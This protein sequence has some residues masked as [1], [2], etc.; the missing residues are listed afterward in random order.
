[1]DTHV[2]EGPLYVQHHK[3]VKKWRRGWAVLFANGPSGVA[4]LEVFEGE[5]PSGEGGGGW[6]ADRKVIRLS[7]C[8]TVLATP[9]EP[10]PQEDSASFCVRTVDRAHVFAAHAQDSGQWVDRIC[11]I[12][13]QGGKGTDSQQS[14]M[15][16][17]LIYESREQN[18]EFRVTMQRTEASERCGLQGAYWLSVGSHALVLSEGDT[19]RALLTWPYRLLRRYGH[20]KGSFSMEAGRRCESGPGS[21]T[22]DT[23]QSGQLFACVEAAIRE[24][25]ALVEEGPA[26]ERGGRSP[27]P[28]GAASFLAPPEPVYSQ[29][30]DCVRTPAPPPEPVYS[31]PLDSL[32]VTPPLSP[33][34]GCHHDDALD[35]LY[36][37]V[38]E[39]PPGPEAGGRE[40]AVCCKPE[41]QGALR[42][43]PVSQR[44]RDVEGHTVTYD[45]CDPCDPAE[46][47][48]QV[49]KHAP[50]HTTWDPDS[51]DIIYD[52]LGVI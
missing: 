28:P 32:E 37:E 3:I 42:G 26:S 52:N 45:P 29:P 50:A 5:R 40:R 9:S 19:R 48:S 6:R 46:L 43:G 36:S 20:D 51:D 17:N 31:D 2:K 47:Y 41:R 24:Q 21:F 27:V 30:L 4:R 1:M 44:A 33:S 39:P 12:A 23:P 18:Q 25:R 14:K 15:E 49:S 10:G 35:P 38:Y 34:S 7:E 11:H 13:F 8:V 16:E 22:F